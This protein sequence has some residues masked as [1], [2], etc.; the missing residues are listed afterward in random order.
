[1]AVDEVRQ[2]RTDGDWGRTASVAGTVAAI[3][4]CLQSLLFSLD[5]SVLRGNPPFQETP[6]GR[7]ADL[8][9]FFAARAERQHDLLWNI[10]LRDVLGPVA[11][12]ALIV[13][14]YAV[15]RAHGGGRAGPQVWGLVPSVGG[16]V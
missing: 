4:L 8:A 14:T 7:A 11:A 10:V 15:V 1:M 5:A 12:V 13:L 3:G 9:T 2:R 16:L 6:A